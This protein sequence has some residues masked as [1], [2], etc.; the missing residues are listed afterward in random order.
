MCQ[1]LLCRYYAVGTV[2]L[3][4]CYPHS[5]PLGILLVGV[6]LGSMKPQTSWI[7]YGY[8]RSHHQG[9]LSSI[10]FILKSHV[11]AGRWSVGRSLAGR[12]AGWLLF[13]GHVIF[14]QS[15]L[16]I[17]HRVPRLDTTYVPVLAILVAQK[18]CEK[19][20][21]TSARHVGKAR[22]VLGNGESLAHWGRSG[23]SEAHSEASED[24]ERR[25]M[26]VLRVLAAAL[27]ALGLSLQV[28]AIRRA[29]TS[30]TV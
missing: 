9:F 26:R 3:Y 13:R 10:L 2:L 15:A 19:L 6:A 14:R 20:R 28:G 4:R 30:M 1:S 18:D 17:V 29:S 11:D 27:C 8:F 23:Q 12:H 25:R 22:V 7:N 24:T 5:S 21:S 16:R